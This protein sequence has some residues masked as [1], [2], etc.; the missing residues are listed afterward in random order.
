MQRINEVHT[1]TAVPFDKI[2][3]N[4]LDADQH[5]LLPIDSLLESA[6]GDEAIALVG[7]GPSLSSV[8]YKLAD[9]NTIILCGSVHDYV[10]DWLSIGDRKIYCIVCD[11]DPI[12]CEYLSEK[13]ERITYLVASQCDKSM[14]EHL[15]DMPK[16]YLWHSAGN[17]A[18]N[19]VFKEGAKL[20]VGGC[21]IGTRAIGMAMAMGFKKIHLFGF[22]SCLSDNYKHHAYDFKKPKEE[23]LGDIK[24]IKIDGPDSPTFKVAGYMLAQIF[25]FQ[26]ILKNY[27]DILDIE[28]FGDGALAY[29]MNKAKSKFTEQKEL[30]NGNS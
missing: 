25:D 16:K 29:I 5:S 19:K 7:G 18:Q 24:D 26:Y 2:V 8:D 6:R 17:E 10:L 21:T 15:K 3:Q 12:M 9:Y 22:D 30:Q 4:I 13:D 11:A 1:Q 20:I 27:A 28:I 14:F 23:S